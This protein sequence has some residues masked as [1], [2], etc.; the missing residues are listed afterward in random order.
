MRDRIVESHL[1]KSAKGGAPGLHNN[2][3]CSSEMWASR[4]I[5]FDKPAFSQENLS[6]LFEEHHSGSHGPNR[7]LHTPRTS[8]F[9]VNSFQPVGIFFCILTALA[10]GRQRRIF[11]APA[12]PLGY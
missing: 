7:S 4:Q 5:R 6:V 1:S 12:P 8:P 3:T 11:H 2:E 9:T 10:G